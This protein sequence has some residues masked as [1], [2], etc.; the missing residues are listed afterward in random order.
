MDTI[1]TYLQ[2][3]LLP[4]LSNKYFI[5]MS[6]PYSGFYWQILNLANWVRI[7]NF[8]IAIMLSKLGRSPKLSARALQA[9]S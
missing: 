4:P 1:S 2:Q 7:A 5:I 3:L 9:A 8:K 6:I